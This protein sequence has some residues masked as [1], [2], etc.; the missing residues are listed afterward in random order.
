MSEVSDLSDKALFAA[1]GQKAERTPLKEAL[2][3]IVHEPN[4]LSSEVV[5]HVPMTEES[6]H[7]PIDHYVVDGYPCS[8]LYLENDVAHAS[9]A[10]VPD[11][12]QAVLHFYATTDKPTGICT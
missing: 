10:D 2:M 4:E 12:Q 5:T 1:F 7:R 3:A 11:V 6:W 9:L 8:P